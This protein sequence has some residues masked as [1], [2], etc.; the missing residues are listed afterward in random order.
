MLGLLNPDQELIPIGEDA[1]LQPLR[2]R[3]AEASAVMQRAA[4]LETRYRRLL[5]DQDAHYME[6]EEPAGSGRFRQATEEE[7][8]EARA[9]LRLDPG[10]MLVTAAYLPEARTAKRRYED[11][12]AAL[13]QAIE[14]KRQVLR[15]KLT[16]QAK[17][18]TKAVEDALDQLLGAIDRREAAAQEAMRIMEQSIPGEDQWAGVRAH[19]EQLTAVIEAIKK[20]YKGLANA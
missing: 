12:R 8:D 19:A 4:V 7:L 13:G 1:E 9:A 16:R 3:Q 15:D 6:V 17:P 18:L 20:E 5:N 2:D 14:R 11:A 10:V